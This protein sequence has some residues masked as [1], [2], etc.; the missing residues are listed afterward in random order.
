MVIGMWHET[1]LYRISEVGE[2]AFRVKLPAYEYFAESFF[3][4]FFTSFDYFWT[5]ISLAFD[6]SDI[7][8]RFYKR[9]N[10]QIVVLEPSLAPF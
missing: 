10:S 5:I 4:V 2:V 8:F 9:E 3:S 7:R 6:H 1:Y